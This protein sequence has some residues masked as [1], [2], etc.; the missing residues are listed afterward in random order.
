MTSKR[1]I[2]LPIIL[3]VGNKCQRL[4]SITKTQ[5][6]GRK[7]FKIRNKI[8][9]LYTFH[10]NRVMVRVPFMTM[11]DRQSKIQL[12]KFKQKKYPVLVV[13]Y[14]IL[15]LDSIYTTIFKNSIF[16]RFLIIILQHFDFRVNR[17]ESSV[18]EK[19][20]NTEPLYPFRHSLRF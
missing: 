10:T 12:Y 3:Q 6:K 4:F 1:I 11:Y 9:S 18:L 20:C 8:D 7:L 17:F 2:L 19:C 15:Q 13:I 16:V 5:G 14:L